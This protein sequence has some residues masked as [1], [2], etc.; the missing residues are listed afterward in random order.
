MR[1]ADALVAA[2]YFAS[3]SDPSITFASGVG[4]GLYTDQSICIIGGAWMARQ[5]A[6]PTNGP[7]APAPAA[8]RG[9]APRRRRAD[10]IT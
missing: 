5:Y 9:W 2:T 3:I 4:L 8:E 10:L 7:G 6:Q 1:R